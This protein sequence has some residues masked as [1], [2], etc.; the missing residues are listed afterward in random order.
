MWSVIFSSEY[1]KNRLSADL[2]WDMVGSSQ[3]SQTHLLDLRRDPWDRKRT[4]KER[5]M[6]GK[7]FGVKTLWSL[8]QDTPHDISALVVRHFSTPL[9]ID[10]SALVSSEQSK[11]KVRVVVTYISFVDFINDVKAV[12]LHQSHNNNKSSEWLLN[13]LRTFKV[14]CWGTGR[15]CSCRSSGV[16][17]HFDEHRWPSVLQYVLTREGEAASHWCHTA[18]SC[19][20]PGDRRWMPEQTSWWQRGL[21]RQ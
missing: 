5:K 2:Y 8:T 3:C 4:Q 21:Y 19:S 17:C 15:Q 1:T 9:V 6:G 20:S 7:K 18:V 10:T 16:T 11:C 12:N 14:T 13:Q